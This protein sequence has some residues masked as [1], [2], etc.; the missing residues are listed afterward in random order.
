[1]DSTDHEILALLV[2]DGRMSFADI[3]RSIGITRASA[4]E[5]VQ[6]LIGNGFI[7]KFTIVVNP[8]L[9]DK[10]VSAFFDVQVTAQTIA[11]VAETLAN[12]KDVSSLYIMSDMCSLHMHVLVKDMGAL[13]AFTH[14]HL[15]GHPDIVNI[16]CKMLMSRIKQR[17]GGPRI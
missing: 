7:E 9:L 3:G 2:E 8:G 4:R 16:Q 1:M 5:R 15:F 6:N 17:R 11:I 10:S 12:L 14:A 13:E